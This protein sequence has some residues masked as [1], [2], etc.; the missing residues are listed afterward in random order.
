M[1]STPPETE[2]EKRLNHI[3]QTYYYCEI[4]KT[5]RHSCYLTIKSYEECPCRKCL[6]LPM[7]TKACDTAYPKTKSIYLD[8]PNRA[9]TDKETQL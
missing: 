8:N 1:A 7:C 9:I 4:C 2:Y 5:R 6:V 3:M